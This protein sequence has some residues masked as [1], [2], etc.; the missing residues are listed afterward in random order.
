MANLRLQ[1]ILKNKVDIIT[2]ECNCQPSIGFIKLMLKEV[3]ELDENDIDESIT[4]GSMDKGIDAIFEQQNEDGENILYIIQSKYFENPDKSLDES[5]V[6]KAILAVS[7]Y[8]LGDSPSANL[9]TKLKNKTELYQERLSNG[10]IDLVSLV[11]ITNG[12]KVNPNLIKELEQFKSQQGGQIKYEVYTESDLSHVFLPMSATPVK[13]INLKIIKDTGGGDKTFIGLTDLG[14]ARGKVVKIDVCDLAE[15]VKQNPNIF[16]SNVRAYQSIR[17]KV[18]EAIA[19]SLCNEESA[20]MFIYLN[21]GITLLCDNSE[22]K[23]GN[24]VA[25][26][27]NPSIIN[28]CQTASTILEIYNQEKLK[29]NTAFVLMRI[30]ES[31]DEDIKRQVIISSNTQTAVK[32]RDL[33]SEEQIQKELE[34]QFETLGYFYERKK[35]LHRGKPEDKI[36]DLEK[37]AQ[38]YLAL[39]LQKPAEAK[40]KKSEIYKS[41]K[42]Q[43]FNDDLTAKQLLIGYILF[44]KINERIKEIKKSVNESRKSILGNSVLHLLPLFREWAIEES[45]KFLSDLE[46]NLSELDN[47]F[48]SKIESVLFRLENSIKEISK[49]E[50]DI[51]NPQYFFKSADSLEK[52]LNL[53]EHKV[54]KIINPLE[55]NFDNFKRQKDLRYYKPDE[56]SLDSVKY[57][58]ITYWNDLFIKLMEIYEKTNPLTEGNID[59]IESGTRTLLLANPDESEKKLRKKMKNGLWLLTNFSSNYLCKFCFA[60][61]KK[62]NLNLLIRLRP[63]RFRKQNKYKKYK[64]NKRK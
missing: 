64:K 40:N 44:N 12:Q 19:S 48:N 25:V 63:T 17:N 58:K 35:G 13:Q 61:A 43:I 42:E 34:K 51:F 26:I 2:N 54:K 52:I 23:P 39:Y 62:L 46:D 15:I 37:A 29:P 9:N 31:K 50:K 60:I 30:I 32:N 1:N 57:N 8:I 55:L 41:Y 6:N 11:F 53:S 28:G 27:D 59:F 24:E 14:F 18:N 38:Y 36:I 10:K 5:A 20:K 3:F 4:D 49:K 56:Y 47:I 16:N 22:I 21:N 33:I 7:N 45:G